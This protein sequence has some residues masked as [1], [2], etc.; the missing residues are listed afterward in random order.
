MKFPNEC[1]RCGVCCLAETCIIG[2]HYYKVKKFDICPG[3]KFED[4]M[5]SCRISHLV[6]LG[7]GCCLKAR[8]FRHGVQYDFASLPDRLKREAAM[9]KR[10]GGLLLCHATK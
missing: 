3:L 10:K 8:A 4:Q 7:D 6:P 9:Q 1:C 2:Q 5:S